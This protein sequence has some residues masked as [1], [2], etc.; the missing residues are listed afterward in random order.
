MVLVAQLSLLVNALVNRLPVRPLRETADG[1][2]ARVSLPPHKEPNMR[3]VMNANRK[4]LLDT[5]GWSEG[6]INSPVTQDGGFDVIVTS[7]DADAKAVHNRFDGYAQHPFANNRPALIINRKGLT[8]T[9][10]GKFQ[11]L[12][13]FWSIYQRMMKLPDFGH[14]SQ[15]QYALQQVYEHQ[16][17]A[18]IDEGHFDLAVTK[19]SPI[20]ASLPGK[21]YEDQRQHPMDALRAQFVRYGGTL[22]TT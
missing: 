20:W 21:G 11:I 3:H 18:L 8:S 19:F 14:D 4:A 5:L 12:L 2:G 17:L 9:A 1:F 13:R 7:I 22:S 6:T 10:S 16:A 15:E